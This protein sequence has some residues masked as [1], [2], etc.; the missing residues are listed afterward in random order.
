MVITVYTVY[1][2][3]Y[4]GMYNVQ[5]TMTLKSNKIIIVLQFIMF[6]Y[7]DSCLNKTYDF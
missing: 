2:Y 1:I 7:I 5:C 4:N 6:T 3:D